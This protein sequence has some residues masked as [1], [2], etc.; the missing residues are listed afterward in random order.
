MFINVV[1]FRRIK[2]LNFFKKVHVL[3]YIFHPYQAANINELRRDAESYV[4]LTEYD[5]NE[6]FNEDTL[7]DSDEM[8]I[9]KI[10][11]SL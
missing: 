5:L 1:N 6:I 2:M 3:N 8:Q 9:D 10:Y 4:Y 11:Q 7:V